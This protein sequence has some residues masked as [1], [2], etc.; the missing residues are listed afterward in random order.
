MTKKGATAKATEKPAIPAAG[1]L[2]AAR[3]SALL[4]TRVVYCGD[5][6][7]ISNNSPSCPIIA[8]I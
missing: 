5:P 4:D 1:K 7:P 8:L 6:P 2:S 3:P